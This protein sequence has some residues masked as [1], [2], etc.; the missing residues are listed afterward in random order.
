MPTRHEI[1][2]TAFIICFEQ[3]F[4]DGGDVS[5]LFEIARDEAC[6]PV[7]ADV[8]ELVNGVLSKRE[9]LDSIISV[10]SD[11]RS[12]ERIPKLNLAILRLA[13][14]EALYCRNVPVN[15]AVSEAVR[16]ARAY[17][18][19]ADVSFING[20]LGAFSRH[21]DYKDRFNG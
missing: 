8:V 11:K 20:V 9:E 17:A 10:F 21:K 5:E 13:I 7:T 6:L 3:L 4:S 18:Y 2:E 14:Y 12:V 15:V 1:R 19:D 16:L